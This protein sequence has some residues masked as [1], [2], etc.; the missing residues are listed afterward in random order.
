M[1]KTL[2]KLGSADLTEF[3]LESRIFGEVFLGRIG[4]GQFDVDF[5]GKGG[6]VSCWSNLKC[7][8]GAASLPDVEGTA[9]S[10]G[11]A[12]EVPRTFQFKNKI[13]GH[14]HPSDIL[15]RDVEGKR[16]LDSHRD[17][18]LA[19]CEGDFRPFD[20]RLVQDILQNHRCHLPVEG[21]VDVKG[22]KSLRKRKRGAC[23]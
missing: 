10:D 9:K 8:A 2:G 1:K 21:G 12:L 3:N 19:D 16:L 18:R 22:L 17:L 20:H 7:N 11:F 4:M 6:D 13:L 23:H 5:P 15:D 14:R